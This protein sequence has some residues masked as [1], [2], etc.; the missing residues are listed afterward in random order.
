M[1]NSNVPKYFWGDVVLTASYL[2]NPM[3]SRVLNFQRPLDVFIETYPHTRSFTTLTP[4]VF[5]CPAFVHDHCIQKSKLDPRAQK[6]IFLGYAPFKKG[7]K[8]YNPITKK[9]FVSH[10]VTFFD[11]QPYYTR[12]SLQGGESHNTGRSFMMEPYCHNV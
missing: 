6:C 12:T 4:K 10:D 5:G 1:F 3:P 9:V 7:Y 2:I 11:T 8:C